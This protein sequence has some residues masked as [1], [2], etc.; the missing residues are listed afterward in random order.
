M[1][2]KGCVL[3]LGK[4]KSCSSRLVFNALESPLAVAVMNFRVVPTSHDIFDV[5]EVAGEI[6]VIED[7]D[8]L[9]V[10]NGV[11]KKHGSHIR[12]SKGTVYRKKS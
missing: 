4:V 7:A 10:L 6:P 12:A 1:N 9:V 3:A 5:G 2:R 8:H 11:G